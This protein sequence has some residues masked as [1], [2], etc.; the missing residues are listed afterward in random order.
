[1]SRFMMDRYRKGSMPVASSLQHMSRFM[2]DRYRKGSM[3]VAS[4]LQFMSRFMMDR[5]R[6]VKQP[7]CLE[8]SV[9]KGRYCINFSKRIV[10]KTCGHFCKVI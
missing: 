7:I 9:Q 5:Y 10:R 2:M 4:S 8:V 6:K 1:M 3:P